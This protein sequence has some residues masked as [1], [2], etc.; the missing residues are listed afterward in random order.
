MNM[1]FKD[2][3]MANLRFSWLHPVKQR[4]LTFVG[5]KK[6]L[7]YDDIADDKVVIYDKGV[8]IPPYSVTEEEFHA[9]YRH[10]ERTVYPLEWVEPLQV[11]C[12]HFLESI[13]NG[14][15]PRSDGEDALKVIKVLETAQRSLMNGG[16]ELQIEY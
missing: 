1:F 4:R 13:R 12:N 15:T 3:I 10:G 7:V 2:G 9:S 16:V 8:E 6:M 14:T 5:S 11:E